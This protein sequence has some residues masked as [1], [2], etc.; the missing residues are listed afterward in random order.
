MLAGTNT[1]FSSNARYRGLTG[2]DENVRSAAVYAL[3][4]W[5]NCSPI[6][7]VNRDDA[8]VEQ[9]IDAFKKSATEAFNP[10]LVHVKTVEEAEKLAAPGS[11]LL[12]RYSPLPTI[13]D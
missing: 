13:S 5:L 6:Y 2:G 10:E 1:L 8:E 7:V 12:L 4:K 11:F 9:F 3:T